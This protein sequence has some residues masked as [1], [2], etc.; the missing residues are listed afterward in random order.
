MHF[1]M[2]NPSSSAFLTTA[3]AIRMVNM[4]LKQAAIRETSSSSY[5]SYC[6]NSLNF[7]TPVVNVPVL[8]K[9]KVS[10]CAY[11]SKELDPLIVTIP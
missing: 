5:P 11:S 1:L 8:S 7:G 9:T 10:T 6:N 3:V 4:F 2:F